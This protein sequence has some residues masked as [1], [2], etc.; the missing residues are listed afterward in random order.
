MPKLSFFDAEIL[1]R[2]TPERPW[3]ALA[4]AM[5][6]GAALLTVGYEVYWRGKEL[7]PG[8]FNNTE[9]LWAQER[10]K[11]TGAARV[12]IGSSRIFFDTDLDV[13][14][15][16]SGVRPV[17]LALEGTSPRIFLKDLAEDE[18]FRGQVVV[19]VTAPLF[20]ST[21]GGLRASVL[22]YARDETLAQRA[23][24]AMT[25]QLERVFGFIDEQSR[26]KRQIAIWPLP[27]RD[28]MRPRFDPRKLEQLGPDRDARLWSRV[29]NDERY[30]NEATSI[31]AL[32]LERNRPPP[33]PDGKP[34]SMPDAAIAA[35]IAEVKANVDKIRARGGDV[36]FLRFPYGG[37]YTQVEDMAFPR[38]RFWDLLISET[39][40]VGVSWHDYPEL[41]GYDLPEWSHLSANEATRY[42]RALVP[43]LYGKFEEKQAE[44][45]SAPPANR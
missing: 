13:W 19:G 11:A 1:E 25:M 23:D 26:P 21:D 20:F 38:A 41:Q 28:G 18:T 10:R 9:A 37:A 15:E 39:D 44:R 32:G 36:A 22:K 17:Q 4:G 3:R 16:L 8:D 33:G 2:E 34:V 40:S 14:E 6:L 7:R 29:V 5:A 31:W 43:I 45:Q 12:L 42:T 27:L 35:T 24:H 30:R